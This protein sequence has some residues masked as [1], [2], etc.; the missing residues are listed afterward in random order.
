[1]QAAFPTQPG[2]FELRDIERPRLDDER[3]AGDVIVRVRNCGICGTDLHYFH[4]SWPAPP[5]CPG[6]EI[7]GE[8]VEVGSRVHR[9]RRG[10]RVAIEPLVVCGH[11]TYCRTGDY[12]LCTAFRL[13][14]TLLDGGLAAL[15]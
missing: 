11:C 3:A 12:Q 2:A 7:S 14:G 10:D 8:V 9:L 1:M 5:V 13:I 4:G 15:V 6:H